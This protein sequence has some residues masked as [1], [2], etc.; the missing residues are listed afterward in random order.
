MHAARVNWPLHISPY[1]TWNELAADAPFFL[2]RWD[3]SKTISPSLFYYQVDARW[4]RSSSVSESSVGA[5]LSSSS[6]SR[7][8]INCT[9]IVLLTPARFGGACNF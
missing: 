7:C 3:G 5:D 8:S 9:T 2:W 4:V 1:R 6:S